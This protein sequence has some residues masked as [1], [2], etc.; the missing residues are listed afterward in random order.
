MQ[1]RSGYRVAKM[2]HQGTP[3]SLGWRSCGTP[4]EP[5]RRARVSDPPKAVAFHAKVRYRSSLLQHMRNDFAAHRQ[6]L[7]HPVAARARLRRHAPSSEGDDNRRGE[8]RHSLDRDG[9][10]R[11]A[12]FSGLRP[13][14]ASARR[15]RHRRPPWRAPPWPIRPRARRS[16]ARPGGPPRCP[17]QRLRRRLRAPAC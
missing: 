16:C 3:H 5:G 9:V 14:R 2:V 4:T 11:M 17:R 8:I 15:G 7:C 13:R 10:Q 1:V 6:G 12:F